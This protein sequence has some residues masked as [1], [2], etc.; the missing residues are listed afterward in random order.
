MPVIN[1]IKQAH[2]MDSLTITTELVRRG[3]AVGEAQKKLDKAAGGHWPF[4]IATFIR[5]ETGF[6]TN[7]EADKVE[8][9]S[10][11]PDEAMLEYRAYLDNS[12][13]S[14]ILDQ[15]EKDKDGERQ[16]RSADATK[17]AWKMASSISRAIGA[18]VTYD[19]MFKDP[20]NDGKVP[21]KGFIEGLTKSKKSNLEKLQAIL[22]TA[23]SI[24]DKMGD[25][26]ASDKSSAQELIQLLFAK[27]GGV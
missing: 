15:I 4:T 27:A 12:L 8:P 24:V 13:P 19:E 22:K 21:S 2:D 18:G 6:Y 5:Q 7:E 17:N 20:E 26:S 10:S 14:D 1:T 16:Y 25:D 23:D 11:T 9:T 3:L